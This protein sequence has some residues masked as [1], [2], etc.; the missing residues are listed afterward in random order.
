MLQK[1]ASAF[2]SRP[3]TP[4]HVHCAPLAPQKFTN[5]DRDFI[6]NRLAER[7]VK[8]EVRELPIGDIMW[9][10]RPRGDSSSRRGTAGGGVL[11]VDVSLSESF[12]VGGFLNYGNINLI[13]L[14]AL[15]GGG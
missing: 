1:H 12:Q 14:S 11:G 8:V 3:L 2:G 15:A 6:G 10:V 5:R 4:T 7:G 13:Q 9:V